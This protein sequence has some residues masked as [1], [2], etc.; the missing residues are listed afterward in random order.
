MSGTQKVRVKGKGQHPNSK[1]ALEP[2][3]FKKGHPGAPGCGRPKGALNLRD[4]MQHYLDIKIEVKSPDGKII[5]DK[6]VLDS[7]IVSLLNKAQQGDVKAIQETFD[8]GFGKEV[9][10]LNVNYSDELK[11]IHDRVPE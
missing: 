5:K 8:R 6:T 4:R 2:T 10:N 9:E 11:R 1:K 7:I 3:I